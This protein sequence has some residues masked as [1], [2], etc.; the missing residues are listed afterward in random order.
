MDRTLLGVTTQ[1]WVDLEAIAMK[2]V[3]CIHQSCIITGTSPSD[4]LV[5]YPG[6]SL[7]GALPLYRGAVGVFYSPSRLGRLHQD[8]N[9]VKQ[10][11]LEQRWLF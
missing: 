11:L 4:F 9:M 1:A 5:S 8:F 7:R 2:G 10:V 3:H 6:H